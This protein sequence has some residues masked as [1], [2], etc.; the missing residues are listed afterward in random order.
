MVSERRP[1]LLPRAVPSPVGPLHAGLDRLDSQANP[2]PTPGSSHSNQSSCLPAHQGRQ[3]PTSRP[4]TPP[5]E[6]AARMERR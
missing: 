1:F 6:I 3:A 4:S 2:K 5:F